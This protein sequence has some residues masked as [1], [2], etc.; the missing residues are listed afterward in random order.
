MGQSFCSFA[1]KPGSRSEG[2][3]LTENGDKGKGDET[4]RFNES[5]LVNTIHGQVDR[6]TA[7]DSTGF[8]ETNGKGPKEGEISMTPMH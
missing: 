5:C 2:A 6:N 8:P 7:A 1:C 4:Y 3:S